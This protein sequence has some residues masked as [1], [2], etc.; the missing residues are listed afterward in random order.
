MFE[1]ERWHENIKFMTPMIS[2]LGEM[3]HIGEYVRSLFDDLRHGKILKI[4]ENVCYFK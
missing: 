4:L 1:A 3:L 2:H